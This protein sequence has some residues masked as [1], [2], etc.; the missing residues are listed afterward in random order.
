[1]YRLIQLDNQLEVRLN[2]VRI[3]NSKYSLNGLLS[4]ISIVGVYSPETH[5]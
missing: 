5:F 1:M 4:E 2:R 3:R